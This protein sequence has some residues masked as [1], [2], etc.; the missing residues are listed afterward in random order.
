MKQNLQNVLLNVLLKF[1][2]GTFRFLCAI[3]AFEV[4]LF[5]FFITSPFALHFT[6]VIKYLHLR[7]LSIPSIGFLNFWVKS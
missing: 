1:E 2:N 7:Y 4:F 3:A 5:R 6:F